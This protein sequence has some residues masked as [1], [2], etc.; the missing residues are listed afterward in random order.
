MT[1]SVGCGRHES[2]QRSFPGGAEQQENERARATAQSR[3]E[4]IH[5]KVLALNQEI[6]S[7]TLQGIQSSE[8][9]RQMRNLSNAKNFVLEESNHLIGL[10]NRTVPVKQREVDQM[11][12]T[13]ARGERPASGGGNHLRGIFIAVVSTMNWLF[14]KRKAGKSANK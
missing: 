7:L 5:L 8:Q 2:N 13:F 1:L 4:E 14:G 10:L 11:I 9:K 3:L 6:S 12:A